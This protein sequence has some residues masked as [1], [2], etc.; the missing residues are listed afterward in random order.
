MKKKMKI[1]KDIWIIKLEKK[2]KSKNPIHLNTV[3]SKEFEVSEIKYDS[4]LNLLLN[5]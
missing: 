1:E 4:I 2:I 3:S 5:K